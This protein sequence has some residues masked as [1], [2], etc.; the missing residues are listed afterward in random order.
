M[1][2]RNRG[3]VNWCHCYVLM[4]Q[5]CRRS[6]KWSEHANRPS[7][8]QWCSSSRSISTERRRTLWAHVI[9]RAMEDK[10]FSRIASIKHRSSNKATETFTVDSAI[11]N[12]FTRNKILEL[13][14]LPLHISPSMVGT[15]EQNA[16]LLGSIIHQKR[17]PTAYV[18][19]TA[20]M[21][22]RHTMHRKTLEDIAFVNS[23]SR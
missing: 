23:K 14:A 1:A 6:E 20:Y 19:N 12:R 2:P 18:M 11:A 7:T 22:F 21:H 15:S 10:T 13:S 3:E 17:Q 8:S 16:L 4:H 5:S 9:N